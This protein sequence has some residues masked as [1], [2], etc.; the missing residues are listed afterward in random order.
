MRDFAKLA[1]AFGLLDYRLFDTRQTRGPSSCP[2]AAHQPFLRR[3]RGRD[4]AP[5]AVDLGDD[6]RNLFLRVVQPD[7]LAGADI[8]RAGVDVNCPDAVL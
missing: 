7:H 4:A 2:A 8:P 5:G 3:I 6:A 1:N